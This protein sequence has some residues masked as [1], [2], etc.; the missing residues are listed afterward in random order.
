MK[1]SENYRFTL[2]WPMNTEEQILAGEFLNKLGNKKSRFI[3]QLIHD[4]ITANPEVINPK[5]TIKFIVNSTPTEN[6]LAEIVRTMVQSELSGKTL[7]QPSPDNFAPKQVIVSTGE[8]IDSMDD[9]FDNLD[10][11]NNP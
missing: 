10:M 1:S 7:L 2:S 8:N 9:M 6:T 11:W 3:V 5:E 4:Y